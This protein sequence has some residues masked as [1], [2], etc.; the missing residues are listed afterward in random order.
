MNSDLRVRE[1][2][3]DLDRAFKLTEDWLLRFNINKCVVMHYV[4]SNTKR[5][6]FINGI[7]LFNLTH[8]HNLY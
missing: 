2:Q 7:Q 3:N 5:P 1:I 6:L 8:F 4:S